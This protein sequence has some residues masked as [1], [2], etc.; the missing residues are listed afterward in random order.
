MHFVEADEVLEAGAA[1]QLYDAGEK[2]RRDSRLTVGLQAAAPRRPHVVQGQNDA[3]AADQ[4]LQRR[5]CAGKIQRFK[6]AADD[7]LSKPGHG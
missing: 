4:R 5:V 7:G 1:Q 3:D 2:A 6:R